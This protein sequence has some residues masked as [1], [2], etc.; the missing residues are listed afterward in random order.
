KSKGYRGGEPLQPRVVQKPARGRHPGVYEQIA[1]DGGRD[2]G[3][4]EHH[5]WASSGWVSADSCPEVVVGAGAGPN[6]ASRATAAANSSGT[7]GGRNGVAARAVPAPSPAMSQD[8]GPPT[9]SGG[10]NSPRKIAG[11][12]ASSPNASMSPFRWVA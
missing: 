7:P 10:H 2:E 3:D 12:T 8:R 6:R 9:L 5:G 4:P 1:T 11:P